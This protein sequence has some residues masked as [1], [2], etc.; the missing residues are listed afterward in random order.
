[1]QEFNG[2]R[3]RQ[4]GFCACQC[5]WGLVYL[6]AVETKMTVPIAATEWRHTGQ[7]ILAAI[8]AG[9]Q[10]FE[11]RTDY[12]MAGL[13]GKSVKDLISIAKVESKGRIP[14]IVTCRDKKQGGVGNYPLKLRVEVLIAAINAGADFIDLEYDNFVIPE[15]QKEIERALSKNRKTK[16]ILSAH[17]FKAKFADIKKLYGEIKKAYPA[18]VPKL[19]YTANHI[20]D[21]FD[22]FDLLHDTKGERIIFCMGQAGLISRIIAKKLGSMVTFA[23]I[24]EGTATA[25]GQLTVEQFRKL[26]RYGFINRNTALYGV[27]ADPVGHSLSPHVHNA[28]FERARLSKVY[29]PLLVQGGREGF[30]RFLDNVLARPWLD[31]KGFSVTIPHKENALNYVKRKKGFVEPLAEKIGA[32]NT[33]L[34]DKSQVTSHKPRLRAYNTD[35]R[36]ALD[37]ITSVMGIKKAGLKDIPAAV[38][39]AG[40]VSRAIV[41][42]LSDV[43]AKITI[44]NR[45]LKRAEDLAKDFGCEFA[46]LDELRNLKVKLVINCTSIGM[47]RTEDRGQRTEGR[48]QKTPLDAKYLKKDMV[49]FDTVYNPI[50]TLLLKQAKKIGAKTIDG[51]S[52]FVNQAAAQ[53]KL[54]T[55]KTADTKLMR[56]VIEG[57][58]KLK[59]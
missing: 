59:S 1:M 26:Y 5:R 41:A 8:K 37:S 18:A 50:E 46:G 13:S 36:S 31:F 43:G 14:V 57:N 9:A 7:Q 52:M 35:Y 33:I 29:L 51:V 28:C 48:R 30:N 6:S 3:W 15:V 4:G 54:F 24:D 44:Y 17:N 55:G 10:M 16:L 32:A 12:Y 22:A 23:S 39:G 11:L 19:V 21:C 20:N 25:P 45:T 40:G 38:I 27:I 34:V 58:L 2:L 53:F 47:K 42:G 56:K 49:V